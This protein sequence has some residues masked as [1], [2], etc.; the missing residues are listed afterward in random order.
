ML[1][2]CTNS[3]D[4]KTNL[5]LYVSSPIMNKNV[6]HIF[7]PANFG[8]TFSADIQVPWRQQR[9]FIEGNK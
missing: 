2:V 7:L 1:Q 5:L 6:I 4:Q 3:F 9:N 8:Y